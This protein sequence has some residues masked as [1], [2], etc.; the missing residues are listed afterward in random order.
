VEEIFPTGGHY[1][2]HTYDKLEKW[3]IDKPVQAYHWLMGRFLFLQNGKLQ[4]YILY[5]IIFILSVIGLPLL[6]EK[7]SEFMEFIKHL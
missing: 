5:G 6:F 3:L 1:E 2:S 7:F 4:V